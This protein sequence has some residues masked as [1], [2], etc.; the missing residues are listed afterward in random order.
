MTRLVGQRGFT[1][2]ELMM[3]ILVAA[4]LMALAVPGFRTLTQNTQQR[5]AV[6]DLNAMLSRMRTEAAGR[7]LPVTACV[8]TNQSS[9]SS[10][11]TW[12]S[13]WILFVDG[14]PYVA[15]SSRNGSR[16]SGETL[17]QAH[18]ALP[19]GVTLRT[20]GPTNVITLDA[21][22]LPINASSGASTRATFR[23]CDERGLSS[24]RAIVLG[25]GGIVRMVNDGKDHTGAVITSC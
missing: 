4:I 19:S 3:T 9:C 5:N 13:G 23:Y 11:S 7:H 8:S 21:D 12:E 10:A 6:S 2:I 1:L 16:D 22:G 20:T 15:G 25:A 24:L 17:I 18:A 14:E